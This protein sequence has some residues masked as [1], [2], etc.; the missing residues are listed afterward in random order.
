MWAT[1]SSPQNALCF[2]CLACVLET[3]P[4]GNTELHLLPFGGTQQVIMGVFTDL[5]VASKLHGQESGWQPITNCSSIFPGGLFEPRGSQQ[6]G[7]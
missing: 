3:V 6:R 7:K 2:L 4:R 1:D 5:H